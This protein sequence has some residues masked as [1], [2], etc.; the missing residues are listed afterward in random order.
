MAIAPAA[1]SARLPVSTD[2]RSRVQPPRVSWQHARGRLDLQQP[3]VMG[4][5]NVTPDSFSDGGRFL[6]PQRAYDHA[7]RM[8]AEGAGIIDVGAESTRPGAA[9]VTEEE[10]LRRL[11]PVIRQLTR[12][13]RLVISVDTSRAPVMRAVLDA[14]AAIINDVRA[15]QGPQA[16]PVVAAGAAG[17]CLM[18]MQGDPAGMQREPHYRN[19]M[20]E[21]HEF[22]AQRV[23]AC[24]DCGIQRDRIA[25]DPGFGFGK[26]AAHNLQLLARLDAYAADGLPVLAG[27]SRKSM[28]QGL[29]GR[30]V[31]QRLAG[32]VALAALA[33]FNGANVVRAHDVAATVDAVRV[34]AALRHAAASKE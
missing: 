33:V 23:R 14:G 8:F 24:E 11:L 28:L 25:V 34:A 15:L 27:L 2:E 12:D 31:E 20:D 22:I 16:L 17:V 13:A 9:A 19:V 26:T 3:V 18:H 32:S 5:L 4:V 21:V 29:T 6:D 1:Q 30:A 7:Q 10:E